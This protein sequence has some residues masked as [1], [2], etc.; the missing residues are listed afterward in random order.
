M[1]LHW[2]R[3]SF[4]KA[5][6]ITAFVVPTFDAGQRLK[7]TLKIICI[8][9]V[10]LLFTIPCLPVSCPASVLIP[11]RVFFGRFLM[12]GRSAFGAVVAAGESPRL[13]SVK[14]KHK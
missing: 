4:K 7:Y 12:L 10:F 11:S 6:H 1:Q 9:S 13:R 2:P 14:P 5:M 8:L 3:L